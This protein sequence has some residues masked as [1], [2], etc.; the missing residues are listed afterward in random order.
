MTHDGHIPDGSMKRA[1]WIA[2]AVILLATVA[3]YMQMKGHAFIYFDDNEYV[4]ENP[5]VAGGLTAENM[6]WALT[7]TELANW[8]PLTFWSHQLDGTLFGLNAG[9]HRM[10]N[11]A[12]HLGCV[13]LVFELFRRMTKSAWAGL[14]IAGAFALHPVNVEVVAWVAQ[15]KTLISTFFTLLSLIAYLEYAKARTARGYA[16]VCLWLG[17]SLMAKPMAVSTPVLF[18]IL[19]YW[20]GGRLK[21]CVDPTSREA[22][23]PQDPTKPVVVLENADSIVPGFD[24]KALPRL[25][26]EKLPMFLMVAVVAGVTLLAQRGAA[27]G[28]EVVGIGH[29]AANACVSYG[30]YLVAMVWPENLAIFYPLTYPTAMQVIGAGLMLAGITWMVARLSARYPYMLTGWLWYVVTLLP[31]IGLVQVGAQ[32]HA[33]RYAY[34]PLLGI[35]LM[36]AMGVPDLLA[37]RVP[38]WKSLL[39]VGTLVLFMAMGINT[40][41]QTAFWVNTRALFQRALDVTPYNAMAAAQVGRAALEEKDYSN[42]A[43]ALDLSLRIN[44]KQP[45]VWASLATCVLRGGRPDIALQILNE[46]LVNY[47]SDASLLYVSALAKAQV[48]ASQDALDTVNK[49]AKPDA[50]ALQVKGM[51]LLSLGKPGEALVVLDES[52]KLSPGKPDTAYMRA[53]ALLALG[54]DAQALEP[55]IYAADHRGDRGSLYKLGML[56]DSLGQQAKA[57]E[58]LGKVAK[59]W[60]DF[61]E[62]RLG[63]AGV[64]LK[65]GDKERAGLLIDDVLR[66]EPG[67]AQAAQMKGKL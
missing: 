30:R 60:P 67:N 8:H 19:D 24:W 41:G 34:T 28:V 17:L 18:L 57:L 40:W 46:P 21:G 32:S 61:F 26:I 49:I 54:K 65:M 39:A 33:D 22:Y 38:H 35:W 15:R 27:S 42:A 63:L 11:L 53:T 51:A 7:S 44:P 56:Y 58:V 37:F 20:P 50:A 25:V 6:R 3:V 13:G 47:P 48:G 52:E 55:L 45:D 31:V 12:W 23:E 29:R 43:E 36:L 59:Q 62:G 16:L 64:Y 1:H 5:H 9:A 10:M 66:R 4:F 14:F 2:L